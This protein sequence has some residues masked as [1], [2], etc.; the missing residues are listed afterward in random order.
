MCLLLHRLPVTKRSVM[1]A[2]NKVH[3]CGAGVDTALGGV[4]QKCT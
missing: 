4:E 3:R 2:T 1:Y